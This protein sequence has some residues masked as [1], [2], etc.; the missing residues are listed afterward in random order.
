MHTPSVSCPAL[1]KPLVHEAIK[2]LALHLLRH[3]TLVVSYAGGRSPWTTSTA[4]ASCAALK[5]TSFVCFLFIY[6]KQECEKEQHHLRSKFSLGRCER[7][8]NK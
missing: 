4:Q 7:I 6:L 3:V 1:H 8:L 2:G 5:S